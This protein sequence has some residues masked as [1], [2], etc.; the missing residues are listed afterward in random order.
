MNKLNI[1]VV[2]ALT[3]GALG[4]VSV[5]HPPTAS[6]QPKYSCSQ[7]HAMAAGYFASADLYFAYGL[8]SLADYYYGKAE[9]IIEASC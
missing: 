5:V 9:G 7:A 2:T 1:L 4:L 3:A 6:A 8:Y